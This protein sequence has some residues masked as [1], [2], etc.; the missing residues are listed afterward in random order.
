MSH[1][2]AP[3]IEILREQFNNAAKRYPGLQCTIAAWH[4]SNKE[5]V[6]CSSGKQAGRN[7]Y[8]IPK[9]FQYG[10][11]ALIYRWNHAPCSAKE[12]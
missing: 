5:P 1:V 8:F 4:T 9:E 12:S 10:R 11:P 7:E 2:L 3:E 6:F